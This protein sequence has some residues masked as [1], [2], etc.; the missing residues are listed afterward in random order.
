MGT[1]CTTISWRPV[2]SDPRY[3]V[4]SSGDVWSERT[5]KTLRPFTADRGGHL[6]VELPEGRVTLHRLVVEAFIG[7]GERGQE[8]RHLNNDPRDNRA[9]NLAWGTRSQNVLDLRSKRTHCPHGHEYTVAN[10]IFNRQGHRRCRECK[11]RYKSAKNSNGQ[12]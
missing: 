2:M 6:A 3:W 7:P 10:S 11:R 1:R 9:E 4:S 12:T 5:N 8:I